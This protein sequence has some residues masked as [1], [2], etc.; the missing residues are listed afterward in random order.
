MNEP[1]A[2]TVPAPLPLPRRLAELVAVRHGLSEANVVFEQAKADGITD[3]V[4]D[5][6]DTDV[7]LS[8]TGVAQAT[9]LGA[10]LARTRAGTGTGPRLDLVLCSPYRRARDTWEAMRREAARLGHAPDVPL[11]IDERLRDREMGVFEL[12]TP[13]AIR[14]RAPAE[15]ER[16]ARLGDWLYRP[17]GGESLADVALRVRTLLAELDAAAPGKRVLVVAHDAVVVCLRHAIDGIG[18]PVPPGGVA[19]VPN[20]SVTRWHGDGTRLRLAEFGSTAHLDRTPPGGLPTTG[21]EPNGPPR[22]I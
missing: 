9:A 10:W 1:D 19:V 2:P 17:P 16:R 22:P 4:L 21:R 18:A 12:H 7:P 3:A 5:G 20:A 11:L 6:S 14:S 15:A 8:A 13:A